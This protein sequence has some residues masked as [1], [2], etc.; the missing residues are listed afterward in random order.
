[1]SGATVIDPAAVGIHQVLVAASP[2]DAI[3]NLALGTRE[4]LRRV[5]NSEIYAQ[6]IAPELAGE[7]IPLVSYR[8]PRPSRNVLIFHA[9]I[10]QSAVHDFLTSRPEPLVLVY[11]NVTPGRYFEPYDPVFADLLV[12]GRR[13]VKRL[14]PRV[15][16]ALADSQ[17]NARELE[18]MGYRDVRVVPPVVNVRHL[19]KVTPRAATMD[20]LATLG[21]PILLSV[22]QLMPHKRP[23]FLVQMMHVAET[24][25]GM[26]VILMLVG[27]H[28]LER[29]TRAIR[30]Q[31]HELNL[32]G[33][34]ITGEVDEGDLAAMIRS[35]GVVVTASEHEG[36]CLPLLEAMTF[37]KP[38]VA[39]ACA[40]IPETV[41]DGALLVPAE[42]GPTFY[43]E[44]LTE[45]FANEPLQRSLRGG[46]TRRLAELELRSP[47]VALV[48]ALLEV[49]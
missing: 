44:A 10:G 8:A 5:G 30:E 27:H 25:L 34:H 20:H 9:S 13:E 36:F 22:G 21:R 31:I 26:D 40:A 41:G 48:D 35:A 39:R 29:Y 33:V 11:H 42:Q 24:Y 2:G 49:V 46:A 18:E 38:I 17:Y 3:T 47:D 32:S 23:D 1:V 37:G 16:C 7:V 12:A 43:A 4:L 28:R 45:L 6:H 14:L 19:S 15:V